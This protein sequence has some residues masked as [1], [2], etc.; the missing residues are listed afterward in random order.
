MDIIQLHKFTSYSLLDL[1]EDLPPVKSRDPLSSTSH[2]HSEVTPRCKEKRRRLSMLVL[3]WEMTTQSFSYTTL[4]QVC[5][6]TSI[7]MM[8][9]SNSTHR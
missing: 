1:A 9:P 8:G 2:L 5:S 3:A 4:V 7:R 6:R